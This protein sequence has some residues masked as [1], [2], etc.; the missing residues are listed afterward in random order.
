MPS[1]DSDLKLGTYRRK[2]RPA[3]GRESFF[4]LVTELSD[5]PDISLEQLSSIL[6]LSVSAI[7]RLLS[8]LRKHGVVKGRLGSLG[9]NFHLLSKSPFSCCSAVML[10]E[11][12]IK[13]LRELSRSEKNQVYRTEEE[14]LDYLSKTLVKRDP[15]KGCVVIEAAFIVMGST[16]INLILNVHAISTS[17]L[18]DFARFGVEQTDG[19]AKVR[20][21]MVAFSVG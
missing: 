5:R 14:L 1:K 21:L 8:R 10:I 9:I 19:I 16:E 7:K 20:T 11:S 18:F 17:I 15:Y 2:R 13:R 3:V 12:D 6:N 4:Q